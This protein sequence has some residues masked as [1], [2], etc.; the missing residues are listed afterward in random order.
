MDV[1]INVEEKQQK[2]SNALIIDLKADIKRHL[3]PG[4]K[5]WVLVFLGSKG[6]WVTTQYR[7]SRWVHQHCHI[8]ILRPT[9]KIC[10]FLWQKIIET[11][12]GAELPNRAS[13]GKGLLVNHTNGIVIHIDA[14][15]GENCN[16]GHQ[17][18]IGVGGRGTERGT[19]TIGDRV[20]IGPGAKL[21]GPI[22]IGNDVAI[23]ANAVVNKDLPNYA[24]A[25]GVPAKV[26]NYKGSKD[27]MS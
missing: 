18:T 5:H 11:L 2:A 7:C 22:T 27:Y 14:V 23:G 8:P 21:F 16:I 3:I 12:T 15:L 20:F 13:I 17:V 1:S 26:K 6:L 25:V 9:L 4:G 19:P 24:V 10:C